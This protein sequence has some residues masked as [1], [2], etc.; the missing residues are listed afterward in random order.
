MYSVFDYGVMAADGVRMS[1]Y[2][3]AIERVV[4]PGS[5]VLDLG[6]GTGICALLAA[7]A[8]ARHVHAVD[9]NPAVWLAQDLAAENG[10]G[11][12]ITVYEESV[13]DVKL[14]EKVDVIVSDMRGQT[15][16]NG[17]HLAAVRDARQRWLA[18]GGISIPSRDRLFVAAIEDE[19][20]SS[21]LATG[22]ESCA[23]LGFGAAAARASILNSV[24]D[25]RHLAFPGSAVITT[26]EAW[27][28]VDYHGESPDVYSGT[29]K[30]VATRRG[31]AHGLAIWFEAT[32]IDD[33]QY[34]N[35]PG[36][37][38]AYSRLFLPFLEGV[39]ITEGA[40]LEVG[41]RADAR[42]QRWS[43]ETRIHDA[44]GAEQ[45]RFRQASFLG[46]PTSPSALLRA[47]SAARP[48]LSARGDRMR[49]LLDTMSA[50]ASTVEELV[51]K[52][53]DGLAA[54]DPLRARIADE[55]RDAIRTFGE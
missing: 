32:L 15:P 35:N 22:W 49:R 13:F 30:L 17:D 33:I 10:F 44:S 19:T 25:D 28:T 16:L 3:R 18:P 9:I 29:V 53:T 55:V 7:R 23:R 54:K 50:G 8:G 47:S 12:R 26:A 1:A 2:A 14:P 45:A 6:S 46:L 41:L 48:R 11:D 34:S 51:A 40:R 5:V 20:I 42:G 39:K 27:S 21:A 4:K 36:Q 31:T 38:L 43:W 52:M 37:R 24:H